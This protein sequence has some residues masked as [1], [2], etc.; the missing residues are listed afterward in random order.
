MTDISLYLKPTQ[1]LDSDH[2]TVREAAGD[3]TRNCASEAEKVVK[4]FNFVRDSIHFNPYTVSVYIEDFVASTILEREKGYCV[5]KAVLLAALGRAAG[6]PSGLCFARIRN[7]RINPDAVERLG[8]NI[9]ACHGYDRFYIGGKW[10]NAAPTFEKQ[11]CEKNRLRLVE[12]DGLHDAVLPE[13]DLDGNPHIEYVEI[14]GPQADLPFEWILAET[15]E[16]WGPRKKAWLSKEDSEGYGM[17]H[18]GSATQ[19][20]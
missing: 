2:K 16:L 4:L 8:T 20:R 15:T 17:P 19:L 18:R 7:H 9:I 13:T 3:L 1:V 6:I 10:I 12:F 5:Q 11:L 14:Y